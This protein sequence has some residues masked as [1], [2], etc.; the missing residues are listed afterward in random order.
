MATPTTT[1][2]FL[3]GT[4]YG[5]IDDDNFKNL[6][7]LKVGEL[8]HQTFAKRHHSADVS[9]EAQKAIDKEDYK[10]WRE[11]A[12]PVL[13][14][15]S[16]A[17]DVAQGTRCSALL[18]AGLILPSEMRVNVKKGDAYQVLPTFSLRWEMDGFTKQD[19]FIVFGSRY[20]ITLPVTKVTE[21]LKPWFRLRELPTASLRNWH[22]GHASRV[23]YVSL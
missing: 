9:S 19:V 12:K 2:S 21:W 10:N 16:P 3:P 23:G 20:K 11:K 5:G 7:G 14:E 1:S 6:F 22:A 8:A 18:I 13:I 17:C 4:V 15:V